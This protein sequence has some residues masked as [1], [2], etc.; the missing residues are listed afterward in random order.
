MLHYETVSPGLTNVLK[1]LM[2]LEELNSFRLVGG[3]S[4]A[5]Q[6]G[7]RKS[8]DIDLFTN[9]ALDTARLQNKLQNHFNSFIISWINQNGFS[10]IINGIKTDIFNWNTPF[11]MPAVEEDNV[12]LMHKEE[13]AAMKF[14]AVT[15]R[16]DKKDFYDI[17][18]LL[19][20]YS[21]QYLLSI[22]CEKYPFFDKVMIIESLTTAKYADDS[23]DPLLLIDLKWSSAKTIITDA[24]ENYYKEQTAG[25]KK[26]QEDRI[27]KA[28]QMIKNKKRKE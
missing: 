24:I 7:H 15:N 6:L 20:E 4:L 5:L 11:I 19:K 23:L 10:C 12:R 17:A 2:Q 13:I 27:N 8:I 26:I 21:F 14:E 16:K 22:C 25:R 9:K 18:F 3:T 1:Q 28:E